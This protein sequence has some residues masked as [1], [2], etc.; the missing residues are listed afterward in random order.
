MKVKVTDEQK[1]KTLLN[2]VQKK[3]QVRTLTFEDIN[4]LAKTAEEKLSVISAKYRKGAVYHAGNCGKFPNAYKY[5]PYGTLVN[6]ERGS[7]DWFIISCSRGDCRG[8]NW[9]H[10]TDEQKKQIADNAIRKVCF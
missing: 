6:L 3:S 10:I 5:V 4:W 8:D 9:M 7:R 1:V 2:E